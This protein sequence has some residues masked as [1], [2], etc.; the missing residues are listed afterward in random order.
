MQEMQVHLQK[1]FVDFGKNRVFVNK[2]L[3]LGKTAIN[4]KKYNFFAKIKNNS[5]FF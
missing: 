3:I 4:L 2:R 1:L 5:C